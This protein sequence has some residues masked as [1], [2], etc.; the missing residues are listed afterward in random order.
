VQSYQRS[1]GRGLNFANFAVID[2]RDP[3]ST[4]VRFKEP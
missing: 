4:I 3:P 2:V 1:P